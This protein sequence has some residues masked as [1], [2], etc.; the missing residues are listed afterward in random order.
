M[1]LHYLDDTH[2]PLYG[3][4]L[5]RGLMSIYDS[6]IIPEQLKVPYPEALAT[7][8]ESAV[9]SHLVAAEHR[10]GFHVA[11]LDY[12][13]VSPHV[14]GKGTI[15]SALTGNGG[16]RTCSAVISTARAL[17]ANLPDHTWINISKRIG[18]YT[19]KGT[20]YEVSK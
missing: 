10:G 15:I 7:L 16:R 13:Q 12:G 5:E 3:G 14:R 18:P 6:G 8:Q 20:Y 9:Y 19:Y 11:L 17:T 4:W 1:I 2:Y